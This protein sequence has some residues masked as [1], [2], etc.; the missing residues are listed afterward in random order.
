MFE[1]LVFSFLVC[2]WSVCAEVLILQNDQISLSFDTSTGGIQSIIDKKLNSEL[3]NSPDEASSFPL[4]KMEFVY[5]NGQ[6]FVDSGN[7]NAI[8]IIDTDENRLILSWDVE[9]LHISTVKVELDVFLNDTSSISNWNLSI[10]II[11]GQPN[12]IGLWSSTLSVPV[13]TGSGENGELF[14]PSGYGEAYFDPIKNTGGSVEGSYPSGGVAMQFMALCDMTDS[15]SS[16]FPVVEETPLIIPTP[17]E[18]GDFQLEPTDITAPLS[19]GYILILNTDIVL[20]LLEIFPFPFP[21]SV[22]GC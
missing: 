18:Y 19:S 8:G 17:T 9:L 22:P 12:A 3:I 13:S 16:G 1:S 14:Y 2:I 4:W 7:R 15:P 6:I 21:S 10:E 20:M 11:D 5:E